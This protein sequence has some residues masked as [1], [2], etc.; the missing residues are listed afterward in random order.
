MPAFESTRLKL[1][2][3]HTWRCSPGY[4]IC[5]LAEGVL[6]FDVPREWVSGP[7]ESSL[8]VYDLAPPDDNCRLDVS[9]LR[10]S[11]I[12]WS[13]LRLEQLIR[14]S[15][16]ARGGENLDIH[17]QRPGVEIAWVE[18]SSVEDGREARSRLAIVRGLNAHAVFTL[19]FWAS[20]AG[21]FTPVWDEI[22]RSIDMGLKVDDPTVGIRP[23]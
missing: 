20:D 11:Q 7:G 5:V 4:K 12:D 14:N 9:L 8:K 1:K 15:I 19:D 23:V 22:M 2:D 18:S 13:G 10:H 6:R 17:R 16:G 3:G 21:R